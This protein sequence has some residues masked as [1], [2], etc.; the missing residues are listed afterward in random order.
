LQ[1]LGE[2]LE[3]MGLDPSKEFGEAG[4][5]MGEAGDNLGEGNTGQATTDQGQ[6]LEA[7]RR[8]AQSMMQQMAGD[9]Q[10]GD[11]QVGPG[12]NGGPDRQRSDPLG[13]SRQAQGLEDG[14]ET[15][16]PGEIDAQRAREIMEA[17]RER[18][19]KPAS[20]LIEKKYLERL[21]E[22]D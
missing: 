18:L 17:I 2:E 10:Q 7:L 1:E 11:Q 20:P 13:R 16:L 14:E 9:G 6:A 21:L 5:E 19:A 4:R 3:G 12:Q 22:T 15:K 8:G